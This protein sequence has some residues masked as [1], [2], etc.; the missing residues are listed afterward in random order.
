MNSEKESAHSNVVQESHQRIVLELS[1]NLLDFDNLNHFIMNLLKLLSE[2]YPI[3]LIVL[4]DGSKILSHA[5]LNSKLL[6]DLDSLNSFLRS[7]Q[8]EKFEEEIGVYSLEETP[9][10]SLVLNGKTIHSALLVQRKGRKTSEDLCLG[11]VGLDPAFRPLQKDFSFFKTVSNLVFFIIEHFPLNNS[12]PDSG[13]SAKEKD[14]RARREYEQRRELLRKLSVQAKTLKNKNMEIEEFVYTISHDLKAPLISIQGFT[15][16]IK[17]EYGEDLPK[18]AQFYLDRI[19][20]NVQIIE[21]QIK[22][23]L[24]YSRIG[25]IVTTPK[26]NLNLR[27]IIEECL[28]QYTT[29]IK[30]NNIKIVISDEFSQIHAEENRMMQLFS[31]LIGNSIKYRGDNPSPIIEIGK[32][33]VDENFITIYVRD[34]GIGVPEKFQSRIFNLFARAPSLRTREIEG[35]GIGLA[36]VKK[37]VETHGGR[38]WMESTEGIGT[39]IFFELPLSQGSSMS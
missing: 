25:R 20:K 3:E 15:A 39:T 12:L 16:A 5:S 33:A 7:L 37:I 14:E 2:I 24:E 34:N 21:M 32:H 29:Q 10:F 8:G 1:Y 36:H 18:E 26:R 9:G 6:E 23:I 22:Q 28:S 38:I 30:N 4:Q 11:Y 31:N 17:E 13:L 19:I 27:E 35:T